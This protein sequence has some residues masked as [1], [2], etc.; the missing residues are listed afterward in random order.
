MPVP[1]M[2]LSTQNHHLDKHLNGPVLSLQVT[3]VDRMYNRDV[4]AYHYNFETGKELSNTEMLEYLATPTTTK[5]LNAVQRAVA[6]HFDTYYGGSDDP[7]YAAELQDAR[8]EPERLSDV[9]TY[10]AVSLL[11]RRSG[12][13][14][15]DVH[16]RRVRNDAGRT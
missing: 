14:R 1:A 7:T 10:F 13:H 16:P 15:A 9:F 3:S 8:T 6:Q 5:T 11:H 12:R 4:G 2:I